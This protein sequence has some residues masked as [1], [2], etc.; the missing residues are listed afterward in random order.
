MDILKLNWM[1]PHRLVEWKGDSRL[2]A[3]AAL[4]PDRHTW[5]HQGSSHMRSWYTGDEK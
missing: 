5:V 4:C 3:V 2:R 1:A